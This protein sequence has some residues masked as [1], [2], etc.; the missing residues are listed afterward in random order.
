MTVVR[1]GG[2]HLRVFNSGLEVWLYDKAN[3]ERDRA[4]RPPLL[5]VVFRT[6]SEPRHAIVLVA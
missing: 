2:S 6:T 1:P 5:Q 4:R 3:R